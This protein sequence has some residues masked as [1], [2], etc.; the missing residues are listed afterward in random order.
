[1][2]L[3]YL[4]WILFCDICMSLYAFIK[5]EMNEFAWVMWFMDC[6]WWT[7]IN[8]GMWF[9]EMVGY[10]CGHEFGMNNNVTLMAWYWYEVKFYIPEL[11]GMDGMKSTWNMN[12]DGLQRI[13]WGV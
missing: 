13:A 7:W 5:Y 9:N 12:G 1:L 3:I 8:L 2:A 11:G 10:I 4:G 6:E